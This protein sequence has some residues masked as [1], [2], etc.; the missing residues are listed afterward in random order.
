MT[1]LTTAP[2]WL[3]AS[4]FLFFLLAAL[5]DMWR[6]EIEDWISAAVAIGAFV[7]VIVDGPANGLWENLLLFA[8]VLAVGMLLFTQGVMGGGDIK[9]LAAS[10][11]WFNLGAGWKMLVAVSILGG[12]ETLIVLLVRQLPWPIAARSLAV[13]RRG[14]AIP[15]GV[16]IAAGMAVMAYWVHP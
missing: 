11:L 12:I 7:A 3:L 5:E 1:L 10:A 2:T 14:E 15:Y 13:L 8:A 9:L 4:L 6:L 16:A